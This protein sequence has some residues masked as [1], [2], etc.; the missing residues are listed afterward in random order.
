MSNKFIIGVILIVVGALLLSYHGYSYI[1]H[2]KV[3]DIGPIKA[4]ADQE[5]RVPISPIFGGLVL[6]GG[7]VLVVTSKRA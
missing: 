4:Y 7:I 2:D 6:A 1:S 5:H 3:V